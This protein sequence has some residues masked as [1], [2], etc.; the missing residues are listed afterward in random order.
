MKS[1]VRLLKYSVLTTYITFLLASTSTL[2][3]VVSQACGPIQPMALAPIPVAINGQQCDLKSQAYTLCVKPTLT[4]PVCPT[5]DSDNAYNTNQLP[6]LQQNIDS[7][8][9]TTREYAAKAKGYNE[10]L[11]KNC[12]ALKKYILDFDANIGNVSPAVLARLG[13]RPP[14]IPSQVMQM[15]IECNK[16]SPAANAAGN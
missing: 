1:N 6:T 9:Q 8:V 10:C 16:L 12:F 13:D 2:A 4:P 3:Q 15:N 5:F 11:R 7:S 14:E